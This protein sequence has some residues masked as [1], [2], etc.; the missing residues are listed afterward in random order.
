M[1]E[2]DDPVIKEIDVYLKKDDS[3]LLYLL[4]LPNCHYLEN[5]KPTAFNFSPSSG[6]I[7]LLMTANDVSQLN[8]DVAPGTSLRHSRIKSEYFLQT[9][10]A[11]NPLSMNNLAVGYPTEDAF[12]LSMLKGT[13]WMQLSECEQSEV[14]LAKEGTSSIRD[15]FEDSYSEDEES[16]ISLPNPTAPSNEKRKSKSVLEAV[17]VRFENV[18]TSGSSNS[19]KPLHQNVSRNV[20]RIPTKGWHLLKVNQNLSIDEKLALLTLDKTIIEE[21]WKV[22]QEIFDED[23]NFFGKFFENEIID[24]PIKVEETGK[25]LPELVFTLLKSGM[26]VRFF[27]LLNQLPYDVNFDEV[28][29]LLNEYALLVQGCW[30]LKSEFSIEEGFEDTRTDIQRTV[31]LVARDFLLYKFTKN[32]VV[33]LRELERMLPIEEHIWRYFL[34]EI[35]RMV[36]RLG[37]QFVHSKDISFLHSFPKVAQKQEEIWKNKYVHLVKV[38]ADYENERTHKKAAVAGTSRKVKSGKSASSDSSCKGSAVVK[39]SPTPARLQPKVKKQSS[40]NSDKNAMGDSN[41]TTILKVEPG[42]ES[43]TV[44]DHFHILDGKKKQKVVVIDK[45][46]NELQAELCSMFQRKRVYSL[47]FITSRV[48]SRF[49]DVCDEMIE[50]CSEAIGAIRI[51]GGKMDKVFYGFIGIDTC[52]ELRR[53]II[54]LLRDKGRF[55]FK[56]FKQACLGKGLTAQTDEQ[57]KSLLKEYCDS[58][59]GVYYLME[60]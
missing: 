1:S 23:F 11:V 44:S 28:L 57:L 54:N 8:F 51:E 55:R 15:S 2:D 12:H 24:V 9:G 52:R 29:S 48:I 21:S 59:Y 39:S 60:T 10:C 19:T 32:R 27:D 22:K 35:A 41:V 45:R 42:T 7:E 47:D 38:I 40:R 30:V 33:L 18:N 43:A 3:N 16:D 14:I 37:W 5:M 4:Q 50:K 6:Q 36:P 17:R 53:Q 58:K 49:P 20:E 34:M 13:A 46:Q 56:T 26:V 31:L 25:P